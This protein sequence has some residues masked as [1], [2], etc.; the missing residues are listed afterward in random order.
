LSYAK[1]INFG[2]L[3]PSLPN[4][5][6]SIVVE[7]HFYLILPFLLFL[8][9]KWKYSLLLLLTVVVFGRGLLYYETGTIQA[10]S[11]FT[12]IGRIDQFLLGIIAYQFR[13]DIIGKHLL[14]ACVFGLFATFYWYF[15]LQ[16]GF[17]K[18]PSYPSPNS[19]WI[20]LPTVEGIFYALIICWYDNSFKHPTGKFSRF[21]ALIGTY[22]Y[23][24]YLLHFFIVFHLAAAINDHIMRLTN[25]YLSLLWAPVGILLML[26]IAYISYRYIES[27][28]LKLRTRYIIANND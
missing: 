15:D 10:L 13:K 5:G 7:F 11:Y 14:I 17:Y 24:I 4:G 19:I 28:F 16:G 23:S 25:N 20:Y 22:A 3:A 27:P 18:N 1:S 2:L 9:K 26:P 12:I 21:V 8:S 6:W